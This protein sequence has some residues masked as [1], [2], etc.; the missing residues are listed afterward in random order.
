MQRFPSGYACGRC[1]AA[2]EGETFDTYE[3]VSCSQFEV[4]RA[5][6]IEEL[7]GCNWT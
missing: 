4:E 7:D 6:D 3:R 5:S 2:R 1:R